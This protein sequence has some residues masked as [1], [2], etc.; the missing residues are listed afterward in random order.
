M[1]MN[2]RI[3]I[4][5]NQDE[6]IPKGT[7][8]FHGTIEKFE[9]SQLTTGSYD[10]VLWL[11]YEPNIARSYIPYSRDSFVDTE[12]LGKPVF[13][14]SVQDIQRSLGIFYDYANIEWEAMLPKNGWSAPKRKDGSYWDRGFFPP[15]IIDDMLTKAGY[16]PKEN[17][18]NRNKKYGRT[19]VITNPNKMGRLFTITVNQDLKVFD[20]AQ[21]RESDLQDIDYHNIPLFRKL[22][23]QGYDG[24]IITDFAQTQELGNFAHNS[25]GIFKHAIKKLSWYSEPSTHPKTGEMN[26]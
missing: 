5:S 24:I 10:D 7:V 4:E 25:V 12:V 16:Q 11:A 13:D 14:K 22:E 20:Y 19:F 1:K 17:H 9:E 15:E 21:D 8:L 23:S 2:F 3:W 26:I 6:I 18:L